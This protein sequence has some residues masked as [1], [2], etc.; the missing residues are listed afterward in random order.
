M[1]RHCYEVKWTTILYRTTF[2][3]HFTNLLLCH[4]KFHDMF[5][6]IV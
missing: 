3:C 6:S 5:A 4:T 2:L 1:I